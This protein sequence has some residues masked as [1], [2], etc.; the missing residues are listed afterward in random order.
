MK[1]LHKPIKGEEAR[2]IDLNDKKLVQLNQK[3][4]GIIRL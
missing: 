4:V 3:A 2:S 1:D